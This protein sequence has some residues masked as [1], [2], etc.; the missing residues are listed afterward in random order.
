MTRSLFIGIVRIY[1]SSPSQLPNKLS[2]FTLITACIN[3]GHTK[4]HGDRF[5]Y[6]RSLPT[7]SI[8][9]K[10]SSVAPPQNHSRP[11]VSAAQ[12]RITNH[13]RHRHPQHPSQPTSI[14]VYN[15]KGSASAGVVLFSASDRPQ[16]HRRAPPLA[17]DRAVESTGGDHDLQQT[18]VVLTFGSHACAASNNTQGDGEEG[19]SSLQGK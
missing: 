5:S 4:T 3:A 16:Y 1:C 2:L 15:S 6:R 8:D 13:T 7:P 14:R 11:A 9:T 12:I 17:T 19:N 10:S 18:A